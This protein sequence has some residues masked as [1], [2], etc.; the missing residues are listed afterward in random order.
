[1]A[2]IRFLLETWVAR[3]PTGSLWLAVATALIFGV[4][5][6]R[7]R[8]S[9]ARAWNWIR[10]LFESLAKAIAFAVLAGLV[11]F[12]LNSSFAAFNKIY[13]SFTT[14]GSLSNLA[15]Q[16]WV[17]AYGG[18]F[19]EQRDLEVTQYVTVET[20]E[21]IQPEGSSVPLYRNVK[22]EQP[23]SENSVT[24]FRGDVTIQDADRERQGATFNA[25]A[26][27]ALY[28]YEIVNPTE[29]FT[30]VEYRFPL[31]SGAKTYRDVSVKLNGREVPWRVSNEALVWDQRLDPGEKAAV[32]VH[33]STWG[34]EGFQYKVS[35]P[36]EIL[37]FKLTISSDIYLG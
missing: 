36:R 2:S 24:R 15:H 33:Y 29:T 7:S 14:G 1:M 34:M 19:F 23:I 30:H 3:E 20:Q 32:S 26:L 8:G 10:S 31:F 18:A 4:T 37:D 27:S 5:F 6:V 35:T 11:Y 25:F 9:N 22:V 12:L 16:E 13:G 17:N 28:E 21:V